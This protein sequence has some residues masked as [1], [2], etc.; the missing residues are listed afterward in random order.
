APSSSWPVPH[1]VRVLGLMFTSSTAPLDR[2]AMNS[3][4]VNVTVRSLEAKTATTETTTIPAATTRSQGRRRRN[5]TRRRSR[6]S[7]M[8][9]PRRREPFAG[10]DGGGHA[11]NSDCS[12]DG[13]SDSAHVG[14][15]T[16]RGDRGARNGRLGRRRVDFL[17]RHPGGRT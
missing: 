11:G 8:A 5:A 9:V 2:A 3:V 14:P 7:P 15:L 13:R 6:D 17:D 10:G 1:T 12:E 16:G 4:S